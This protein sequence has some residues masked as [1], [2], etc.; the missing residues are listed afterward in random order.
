MSQWCYADVWEAVAAGQPGR[1]AVIQGDQVLSWGAFNAAADS[2]AAAFVAAGAG[3]QAKVGCYLHNGA[4][5]LIVCAA[6]LVRYAEAGVPPTDTPTACGM[7]A[8]VAGLAV[9]VADE[10]MP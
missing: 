9:A 7:A 6:A 4:E 8:I 5:Y 3:P 10:P 2:L 1:A